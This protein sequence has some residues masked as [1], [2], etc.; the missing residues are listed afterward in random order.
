[1]PGET[2]HRYHWDRTLPPKPLKGQVG[3]HLCPPT[4]HH[5]VGLPLAQGRGAG[6]ALSS[7]RG[8]QETPGQPPPHPQRHSRGI[9]SQGPPAVLLHVL[10][11]VDFKHLVGVHRHQDASDI[12]LPG[13][14]RPQ[15]LGLLAALLPSFREPVSMGPGIW[16]PS[17]RG[18]LTARWVIYSG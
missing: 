11:P 16:L 9:F 18:P 5:Q 15:C 13:R 1:M 6:G 3:E 10:R 2:G 8:T 4:A 17:T 7:D 12:G 14:Q